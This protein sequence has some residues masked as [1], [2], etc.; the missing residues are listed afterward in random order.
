MRERDRESSRFKRRS[1][2]LTRS[3]DMRPWIA[4]GF[5]CPGCRISARANDL[6]TAQTLGISPLTPRAYLDGARVGSYFV[7]FLR[8]RDSVDSLRS[9]SGAISFFSLPMSACF[10]ASLSRS[11]SARVFVVIDL[12]ARVEATP[13]L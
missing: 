4:G 1:Q 12:R 10:S 3:A 2:W 13:I 11:S 5:L 9:M 6:I 7:G 8:G